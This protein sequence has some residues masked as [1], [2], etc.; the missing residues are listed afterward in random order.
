MNIE[1][2]DIKDFIAGGAI[3]AGSLVKFSA[4]GT[5]VVATA[6]TD[7]IVGVSVPGLDAATG[8]RVDVIVDGIA[9]VK[10]AGVI[11]RGGFVT[12]NGAGLGVACAPTTGT[13]ARSIG[14]ALETSAS[15]DI[16]P[17][18]IAHSQ[19]TTP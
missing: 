1:G 13:V 17:V 8:D 14:M 9:D 18:K 19:V 4:S 3:P 15:G 6:A 11:A 2:Q 12:S 16:I 7:S 5:V 10:T